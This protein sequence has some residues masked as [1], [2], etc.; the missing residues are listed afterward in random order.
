MQC[1]DCDPITL[2]GYI[3]CGQCQ[4]RSWPLEAEWAGNFILAAYHSAHERNCQQRRQ[5]GVVL[6]N[7]AGDDRTVPKVQRPPRPD[8]NR[9]KALTRTGDRCRNGITAQDLCGT[10]L[11]MNRHQRNGAS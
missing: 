8:T 2:A 7:I 4:A 1:A 3:I 9:C 5:Y 6:L 10:H 11:A